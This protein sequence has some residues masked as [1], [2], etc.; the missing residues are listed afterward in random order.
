MRTSHLAIRRMIANKKSKLTDEQIFS[1]PQYAAYLTDIAEGVTKRYGRSS[2]VKTYWDISPHADIAQTDNRIIVLNAGNYL[3]RSFPTRELMADSLLGIIGHECGHIIY[4][5]FTMLGTYHQTL[6]GGRFY[7]Q[8][9]DDLSSKQE[10][11]LRQILEYFEDKDEAVI[12]A[13]AQIAHTLVK[14]M[15]DV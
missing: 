7:P 1:S 6:L 14:I 5:D 13:V 12:S 11:S 10:R 3:T 2:K 4:S 8:E 15:E 9:P